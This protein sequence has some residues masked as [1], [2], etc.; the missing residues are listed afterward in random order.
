MVRIYARSGPHV[1]GH[2][3]SDENA[4]ENV[5]PQLQLH[6]NM[7]KVEGVVITMLPE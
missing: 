5:K 6:G 3:R 7:Y 2:K 1:H 4:T